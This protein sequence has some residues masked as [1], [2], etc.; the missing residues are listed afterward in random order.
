MTLN[1]LWW[2]TNTRDGDGEDA[3]QGE[4]IEYTTD[5]KALKH[6]VKTKQNGKTEKQDQQRRQTFSDWL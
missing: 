4:I 3:R 2:K 1:I 5:Y 6:V